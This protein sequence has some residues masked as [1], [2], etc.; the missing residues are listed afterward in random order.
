M[1]ARDATVS[2]FVARRGGPHLWVLAVKA[3]ASPLR[4]EGD[5]RQEVGL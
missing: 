3:A 4:G 2:P 1:V 5:D